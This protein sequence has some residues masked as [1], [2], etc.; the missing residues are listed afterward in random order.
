MVRDEADIIEAFVR[1]NLCFVE[2]LAI[3]D[4]ASVDGTSEIL[5]ALQREGIR[6]TVERD[7]SPAQRQQETLTRL[8]RQLLRDGADLVFALDADE[9]LK[10]RE[11]ALLAHGLARLPAGIN[12]G[13]EWQTYVPSRW[14]EDGVHPLAIAS[15]RLASERHGFCKVAVTRSFLERTDT[16]IGPGSHAVLR[17]PGLEM[18]PFAR[19][20]PEVASL[21]H[22]PVR[23]AA[24]LMAKVRTGWEAHVA[25]NRSN[26]N[27]AFHWRELYEE[28]AAGDAPTPQRLAVIAANYGLKM[29]KWHEL[30]AI[31]TVEDPL[32]TCELRYASLAR[33]S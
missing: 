2:H 24:Q 15:H 1:H 19:L 8:A 9:F 29:E 12:I 6:I 21:A 4:H 27:L 31:A 26:P 18:L 30:G 25:A 22:L 13:L 32:P 11:P 5:D 3:V 28:F 14:L 7:D 17:M 10:I 33:R 20:V 16:I 23:S